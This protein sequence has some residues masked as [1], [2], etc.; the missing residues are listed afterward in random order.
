MKRMLEDEDDLEV[1]RGPYSDM[2]STGDTSMLN[3]C[4]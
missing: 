1:D 4:S 2:N 3:I